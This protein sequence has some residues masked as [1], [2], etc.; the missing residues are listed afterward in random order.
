MGPL[1]ELTASC[2]DKP[3]LAFAVGNLPKDGLKV[4]IPVQ[5]AG[6][7]REPPECQGQSL[8]S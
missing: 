8:R 2:P 4:N 3:L 7:R 1:T 5:A 6:I